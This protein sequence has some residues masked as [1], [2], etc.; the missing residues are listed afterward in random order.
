MRLP[1]FSRMEMMAEVG[2][3]RQMYS[4][5]PEDEIKIKMEDCGDADPREETW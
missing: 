4:R 3:Y 2:A 1:S 5:L